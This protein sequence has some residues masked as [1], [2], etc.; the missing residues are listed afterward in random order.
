[1]VGQVLS[2]VHIAQIGGLPAQKPE[3]HAALDVHGVPF[4]L[5]ALET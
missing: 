3:V 4:E 1:L 5:R 2:A